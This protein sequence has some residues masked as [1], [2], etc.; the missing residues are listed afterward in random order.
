MLNVKEGGTLSPTGLAHL[1]EGEG[2]KV[3]IRIEIYVRAEAVTAVGRIVAVRVRNARWG[4][5]GRLRVLC[6]RMALANLDADCAAGARGYPRPEGYSV[7]CFTLQNS[8]VDRRTKVN[9]QLPAPLRK[10][11]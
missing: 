4:S 2:K 1:L 6:V 8:A 9:P 3:P 10:R 11:A 5:A 7:K